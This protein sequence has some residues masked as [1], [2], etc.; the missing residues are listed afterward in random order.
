MLIEVKL[1]ASMQGAHSCSTTAEQ[2]DTN[3]M[4]LAAVMSRKSIGVLGTIDI[5]SFLTSFLFLFSFFKSSTVIAS[6]PRALASSQCLWSPRTHTYQGQKTI[7][8]VAETVSPQLNLSPALTVP[9]QQQKMV[10]WRLCWQYL[11]ARS[12]H[13]RQLDSS[14][15]TLVLLGVI[16]F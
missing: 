9:R 13:V 10:Q 12:R 11:H 6:M 16:V 4:M 3:L 5:P 1:F 8:G 2:Q 14:T 7:S 15:E